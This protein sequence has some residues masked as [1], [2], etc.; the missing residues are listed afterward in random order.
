MMYENVCFFTTQTQILN[1]F[2]IITVYKSGEHVNREKR[3]MVQI[4]DLRIS[5]VYVHLLPLQFQVH[6][7]VINQTMRVSESASNSLQI[8][9]RLD[10]V[11]LT[12]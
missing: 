6:E 8:L 7:I 10:F 11:A 12:A 5:T 3:K 2:L 1:F 9:R 4:F